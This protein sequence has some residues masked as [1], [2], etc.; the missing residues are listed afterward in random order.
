MSEQ[1]DTRSNYAPEVRAQYEEYPFP[2]RD[3][4]D[5][6]KRLVVTD[7]DSL[8]KLNH[9]CFAGRQT[10]GNGFRALV[11]VAAQAITRSSLPSSCETTMRASPT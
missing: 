3:P 2:L 4:R 9:Y 7:Q 11:R 5:E 1:S 6:S 10:F 8:G